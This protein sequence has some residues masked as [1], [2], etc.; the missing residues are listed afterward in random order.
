MTS[1]IWVRLRTMPEFMI[2]WKRKAV[3]QWFYLPQV[4]KDQKEAEARAKASKAG[5]YKIEVVRINPVTVYEGND[6]AVQP[7][8]MD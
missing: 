6:D 7:A 8:D 2:R 5:F 1:A 4:F 3:N